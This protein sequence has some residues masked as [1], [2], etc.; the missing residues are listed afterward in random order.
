MF[1]AVVFLLLHSFYFMIL[2]HKNVWIKY[3]RFALNLVET[4]YCQPQTKNLAKTFEALI[5]TIY[6]L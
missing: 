4:N 1:D 2:S 6:M 3:N 5:K